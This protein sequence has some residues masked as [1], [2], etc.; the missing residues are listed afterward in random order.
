MFGW[1]DAM[2]QSHVAT[3]SRSLLNLFLT[4]TMYIHVKQPSCYFHHN[5]FGHVPTI[6]NGAHGFVIFNGVPCFKVLQWN[7]SQIIF[8]LVQTFQLCGS[9][10][11]CVWNTHFSLLNFS[12]CTFCRNRGALAIDATKFEY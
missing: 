1:I 3:S 12:L 9:I 8:G 4:I 2:F 7:I 10:Y 11:L 5:I 6:I